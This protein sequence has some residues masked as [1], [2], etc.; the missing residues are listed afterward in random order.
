MPGLLVVGHDPLAGP[1]VVVD[2]AHH[3]M[4]TRPDTREDRGVVRQRDRRELRH[5]SPAQ[6]QP[7][8]DEPRHRWQ[9]AGLGQVQEVRTVRPVPEDSHH[10]ARSLP[11]EVCRERPSVERLTLGVAQVF[12]VDPREDGHRRANIDQPGVLVEHAERADTDTREHQRRTRLD[13]IEGPVLPDMPTLVGEVVPRGVDDGQVGAAIGIGEE[14]QQPLGGIRIGVGPGLGRAGIGQ[15]ARR[16]LIGEEGHRVLAGDGVHSLKDLLTTTG[17]QPGPPEMVGRMRG[18]HSIHRL[19]PDD[20]V[21][22]RSEVGR[23]QSPDHPVP[24]P[25][26]V[27][28]RIPSPVPVLGRPHAHGLPFNVVQPR[29]ASHAASRLALWAE[30]RGMPS[31]TEIVNGA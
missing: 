6:R 3:P 20:E 9:F 21:D 28:S 31:T 12:R 5:R 4:P 15:L 14:G 13:D 2:V 22:D 26:P 1:A 16:A 19:D 10:R 8:L 18:R 29:A 17:M 30:A 7:A 23:T 25:C 27:P 11:R 24:I